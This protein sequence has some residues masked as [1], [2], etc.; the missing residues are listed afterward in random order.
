MGMNGFVWQ[1]EEVKRELYQRVLHWYNPTY[2]PDSE[3]DHGIPFH[4]LTEQEFCDTCKAAC[5][6]R[7]TMPKAGGRHV[8]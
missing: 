1:N 4:L 5:A 6:A 7:A 2:T 3:E 8:A